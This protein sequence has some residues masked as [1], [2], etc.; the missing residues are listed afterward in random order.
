MSNA[1]RLGIAALILCMIIGAVVIIVLTRDNDDTITRPTVK[2]WQQRYIKGVDN[3]SIRTHAQY[4]SAQSHV[5]YI[6]QFIALLMIDDP[7]I[8]GHSYG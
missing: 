3:D 2:E 7:C 8:I 1:S 5:V 6:F 4:Y